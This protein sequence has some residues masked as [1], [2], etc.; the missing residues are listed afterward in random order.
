MRTKEELLTLIDEAIVI[1]RKRGGAKTVY[2]DKDGKLCA[3]G[4]LIVAI[5]PKYE[6]NLM[7]VDSENSKSVDVYEEELNLRKLQT[8]AANNDKFDNNHENNSTK[9]LQIYR[10]YILA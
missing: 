6:D 4:C 7:D 8:L 2:K 1:S 3:V 9:A 5:N 10:D